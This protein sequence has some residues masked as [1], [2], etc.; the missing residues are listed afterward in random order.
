MCRLRLNV[1]PFGHIWAKPSYFAKQHILRQQ[2][3]SR[4]AALIASG[5]IL[6]F[7]SIFAISVTRSS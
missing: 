2:H 1:I 6:S 3:I 5:V 4:S 7:E